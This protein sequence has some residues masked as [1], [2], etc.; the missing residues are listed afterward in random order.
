MTNLLRAAL[1]AGYRHIDTAKHYAN[2]KFI[3]DSLQIIF[4]EG[5]YKREDL[6]IATKILG[7]K[8]TSVEEIV[9]G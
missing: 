8:G 2:E 1:D 6:F 7:T 4:S 5:K 9:Q 3:G